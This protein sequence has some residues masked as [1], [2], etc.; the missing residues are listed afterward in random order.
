M[1]LSYSMVLNVPKTYT[2]TDIAYTTLSEF[3]AG[4][5]S[6]F[7]TVALALADIKI[8]FE[9]SRGRYAFDMNGLIFQSH[10]DTIDPL[11]EIRLYGSFLRSV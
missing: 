4:A 1:A 5:S 6:T 2:L 3:T 7:A 10:V 9:G 8:G 11:R